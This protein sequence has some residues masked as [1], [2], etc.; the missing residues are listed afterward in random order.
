MDRKPLKTIVVLDA[1]GGETF[2]DAVRHAMPQA[3]VVRPTSDDERS[4]AIAV[5]DLVIGG[6]L[7]DEELESASHLFWHHVP[8]VGVEGILRAH[9]NHRGILLTNSS[10]ANAPNI[11]EHVIAMMLTFARN[12]QTYAVA[13]EHHEWRDWEH[14]PRSFELGDQVV[15]CLGTG[16]IGQAVASRLRGFG[17]TLVGANRSG[18]PVAG[19][20]RCVPFDA[21]SA[22]IGHADHVVS[23]LPMTSETAGIVSEA[24]IA[25]M[26]P[27]AYF[28][29]V[30][31]GGTVDQEA[32]QAALESGHLAGAGLDVTT[33]E[34]L[35][36]DHPL[37]DAPNVMIT[38]HSSGNSPQYPVRTTQLMVE[39]L[40][41]YQ[42]GEELLNV[43]NP[44]QGY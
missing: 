14:R 18:R 44:D 21:L 6:R 19:F 30:G 13:T 4:A 3:T 41:R 28:Y 34:P 35:P 9:H 1:P 26:K 2:V 8:W 20:D 12:L 43:V 25:K 27:G 22:E 40:R 42:A 36:A 31:R 33:P 5:A 17:A 11:S 7:S 29:N 10:G 32:L 16:A 39:Q 23:S 37:W 24:L 15:L 38:S